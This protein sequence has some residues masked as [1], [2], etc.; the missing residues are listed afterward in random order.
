M[1]APQRARPCPLCEA[2]AGTGGD[3]VVGL[4][5]EAAFADHCLE[6]HPE[7]DWRSAWEMPMTAR[8]SRPEPVR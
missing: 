2:E 4:F 8:R 5:R 3:Q 1:T 6:A 7:F